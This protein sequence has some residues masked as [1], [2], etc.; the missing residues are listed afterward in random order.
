MKKAAFRIPPCGKG[1]TVEATGVKAFGAFGEM[2]TLLGPMAVEDGLFAFVKMVPREERRIGVVGF[3]GGGGTVFAAGTDVLQETLGGSRERKGGMQ[4]CVDGE[5]VGSFAPDGPGSDVIEEFVFVASRE[6]I[7]ATFG[8][9][10]PRADLAFGEVAEES[11]LVIAEDRLDAKAFEEA[12]KRGAIGSAI[13][14][15]SER[16]EDIAIRSVARNNKHLLKGGKRGVKITEEK[17]AIHKKSRRKFEEE[18][19]RQRE[20]SRRRKQ[21]PRKE[22]GRKDEGIRGSRGKRRGAA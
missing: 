5:P 20:G 11:S 19:P 1:A 2:K 21:L 14:D 8:G 7:R 6:K 15:I 3:G 4:T 12:E 18:R 9:S 16:E 13:D 10:D 17:N 22:F